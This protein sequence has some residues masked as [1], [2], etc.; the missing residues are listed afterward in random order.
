MERDTRCIDALRELAATVGDRLQIVELDAM[1]FDLEAPGRYIGK[2]APPTC[3]TIPLA[4]GW[5]RSSLSTK[6]SNAQSEV[7]DRLIATPGSKTYG[8]ISIAAQWRCEVKPLYFTRPRVHPTAESRSTVVEF[9]P[10]PAPVAEADSDA[11]KVQSLL[12]FLNAAKCCGPALK[13][14]STIRRLKR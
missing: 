2:I 11:S 7:A 10:R 6:W 1:E 12:R 13:V 5:L 4:D 3:P 8:R 14:Y 9:V